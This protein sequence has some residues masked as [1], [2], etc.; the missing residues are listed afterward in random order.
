MRIRSRMR[1]SSTVSV[2]LRLLM[3]PKTGWAETRSFSTRSARTY[4]TVRI[5]HPT[6]S[7]NSDDDIGPSCCKDSSTARTFCRCNISANSSAGKCSATPT[8]PWY[9]DQ[10]FLKHVRNIAFS[11]N[12]ADNEISPNASKNLI[13]NPNIK[14]SMLVIEN[15]KDSDSY[16]Y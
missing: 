10:I 5:E 11:I 13:L 3:S 9:P 8:Q 7:S 4:R 1:S 14:D 6:F 2:Y 12:V 16:S 15:I